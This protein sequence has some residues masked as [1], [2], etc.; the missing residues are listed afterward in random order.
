M[1]SLMMTTNN[2]FDL[3]GG[4]KRRNDAKGDQYMGVMF[5]SCCY[6]LLGVKLMIILRSMR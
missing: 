4:G 5:T 2:R 6:A 3:L 1:V